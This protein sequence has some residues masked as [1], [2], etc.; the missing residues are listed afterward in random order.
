ML[1][2]SSSYFIAIMYTIVAQKVTQCFGK[3]MKPDERSENPF[4]HTVCLN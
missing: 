2:D 3:Y 1:F 4:D